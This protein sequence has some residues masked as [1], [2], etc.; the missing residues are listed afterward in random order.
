MFVFAKNETSIL[1]AA[2]IQ[3]PNK[4]QEA[5]LMNKLASWLSETYNL[6]AH[7]QNTTLIGGGNLKPTNEVITA[8][9]TWL[10]ENI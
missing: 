4:A 8:I 10:L 2:D 1:F 3:K 6:R 5:Q 7:V 9:R